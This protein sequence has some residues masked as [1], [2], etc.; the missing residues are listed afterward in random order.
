[1][2]FIANA[3]AQTIDDHTDH[4]QHG[5]EPMPE[6]NAAD[7]PPNDAEPMPAAVHT[8]HSAHETES[9]LPASQPGNGQNAQEQVMNHDVIE[10]DPQRGLAATRSPHE[11]SGGYTRQQ[12]LYALPENDQHSLMDET[13]FTR[14]LVNR[15]E[16]IDKDDADATR[17]DIQLW[18]GKTF[19]RFVLKAEGEVENDTVVDSR[20]ELLWSRATSKF[21]DTQLGMR[22][23]DG[24][25]PQR[26][27]IAAGVQGVAPY[28]FETHAT[29]FIGENGRTAI[30]FEAEYEGRITQRLT[31]KPRI[32]V[33]VYGK[34]DPERGIGAGLSDIS[35]GLR[36]QYQFTRQFIPYLGVER[37]QQFGET[38]DLLPAGFDDTDTRMVAGLKFWF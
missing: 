2:L 36:L 28:W 6:T 11:Y 7:H 27:W 13:R 32:D 1:M 16:N 17:Y 30:G 29:A 24:D 20:T 25:G 33:N 37:V 21:W 5:A 38:A 26:R 12:G 19:N 9:T 18:Y 4:G 8:D 14:L 23:D 34:D 10:A 31:L 35:L 15:F 22:F 3:S